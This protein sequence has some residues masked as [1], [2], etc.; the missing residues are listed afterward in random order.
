MKKHSTQCPVVTM[1]GSQ[2]FITLFGVLVVGAI[3]VATALSLLF[4]SVGSSNASLAILRSVSARALV[5]ACAEEALEQI[6]NA[7]VF[8]GTGALTNREGTCAYAVTSLG[9]Q[10][11]LIEATGTVVAVVRK[12]RVNI[13]R[14]TPR[15]QVVSWQ[16]VAD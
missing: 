5:N 6:H 2:G 8:T 13:D 11:R 16:E 1:N 3:G 9:G 7:P 14:I 12:V 15:I 4:I 10:N